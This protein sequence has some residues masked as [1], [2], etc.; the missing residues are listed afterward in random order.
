[1]KMKTV[2]T[3]FVAIDVSS[4]FTSFDLHLI[5]SAK[6]RTVISVTA[7]GLN[8][9][10]FYR[11]RGKSSSFQHQLQINCGVLYL[12]FYLHRCG[13]VWDHKYRQGFVDLKLIPYQNCVIL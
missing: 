11:D 4:Q 8:K 7:F 1:M 5:F 9:L 6:W 10:Q 12:H 3:V 13:M 2:G